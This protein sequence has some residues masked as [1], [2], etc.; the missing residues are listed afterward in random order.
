MLPLHSSNAGTWL[1]RLEEVRID[2]HKSADISDDCG[3]AQ[4]DAGVLD[5]IMQVIEQQPDV[6]EGIAIN[7]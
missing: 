3:N 1:S 7:M 6:L 5:D 2:D 4:V